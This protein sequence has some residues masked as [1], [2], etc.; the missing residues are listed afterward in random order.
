M[1]PAYPTGAALPPRA[2]VV[3]G[4]S[5]NVT[6]IDTSSHQ[7]I[8]QVVVGDEPMLPALSPD[9]RLLLV[10]NRDSMNATVID[11]A[12]LTVV[13]TV[14]VQDGASGC[15]F[16]TDGTLAY[17]ANEYSHTVSF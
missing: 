13:H 4:G 2:Y 10:T 11:T 1:P 7:V 17:V 3:G 5:D 16:S 8:G 14:D 12:S 9:G 15:A 6:V